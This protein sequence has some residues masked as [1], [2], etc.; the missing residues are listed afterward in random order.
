VTTRLL[1]FVHIP[2]TAGTTFISILRRNFDSRQIL[3]IDGLNPEKTFS[4][5]EQSGARTDHYR[6]L[7]GHWSIKFEKFFANREIVRIV[8]LRHPL[9]HF[10]STYFYIRQTPTHLQHDVANRLSLQE[11]L[12]FRKSINLDN[13]QV[14]HLGGIPTNMVAGSMDFD[15]AGDE[16]LEQAKGELD[17]CRYPFLTEKFDEALLILQ[18][19]RILTTVKYTRKNVSR[20][21]RHRDESIG[22]DLVDAILSANRFDAALYAHAKAVNGEMVRAYP[23]VEPPR[24]FLNRLFFRD[25]SS[26]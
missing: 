22:S 16:V 25:M 18:H 5:L 2:K 13:L 15:T 6:L 3:Q 4:E 19:D 9:E 1:N 20:T 12:V 24:R 23:D 17:A 21:P 7:I 8:F 10:L 14:R 26:R 11:F